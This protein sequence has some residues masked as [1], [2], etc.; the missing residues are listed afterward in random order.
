MLIGDG[1]SDFLAS[2]CVD[3][4]IGYGGVVS[5]DNVAKNSQVFRFF[6]FVIAHS[7]S[8]RRGKPHSTTEST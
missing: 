7:A 8:S 1:M 2:S 4:F 6:A 5:R 3:Q